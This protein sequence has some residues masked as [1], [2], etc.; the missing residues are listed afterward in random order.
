MTHLPG[1]RAAHPLHHLIHLVHLV[2]LIHLIHLMRLTN[3][4]HLMHLIY[5][6]HYIQRH[7]PPI[8]CSQNSVSSLLVALETNN[9]KQISTN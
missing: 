9:L 7:S 5:S 8:V 3:L 4:M 6:F 1:A 2:H